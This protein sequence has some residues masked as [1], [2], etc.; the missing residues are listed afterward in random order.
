M[1]DFLI[2]RAKQMVVVS[3][4][5]F[6]YVCL[7]NTSLIH[8]TL[9]TLHTFFSS[10]PILCTSKDLILPR[11]YYW[12]RDCGS[13][14][15]CHREGHAPLVSEWVM[16]QPLPWKSKEN[17]SG[18]CLKVLSGLCFER[19]RR[20]MKMMAGYI[21]LKYLT[22]VIIWKGPVWLLHK[23][24]ISYEI[25]KQKK[26]CFIYLQ[27]FDIFCIKHDYFEIILYSFN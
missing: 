6:V 18:W 8:D 17:V 14:W 3:F 10:L 26:Q 22:S 20:V 13:L 12:T 1:Q 21:C 16:Q 4:N 15:C 27:I 11:V 2:C 5:F 9:F 24:V 19:R 7:K 25:V 23:G